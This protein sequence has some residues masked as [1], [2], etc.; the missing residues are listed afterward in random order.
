MVHYS[1]E[2]WKAFL[3]GT[4]E[5]EKCGAMEEHLLTCEQC[6][7][8]YLSFFSEEGEA[9][10]V[11]EFHPRFTYGVMKRIEGMEAKQREKAKRRDIFY[12]FAA[13]CLTLFFMFAGAFEGFAEIIPE[14]TKA[15]MEI[16]ASSGAGNQGIIEFGWSEK[17]MNS[18]VMFLDT[19]KPKGEEVLD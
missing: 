13:A 17:L 15:D 19:M 9:G 4:L 14:I 8:E 2:E 7:S 12:Y 16:F 3:E 18:T 10:G 11:I 5:E 6:V 1:R